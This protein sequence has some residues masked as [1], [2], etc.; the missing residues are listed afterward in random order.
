M[1]IEIT[2]AGEHLSLLALFAGLGV[3]SILGYRK[4]SSAEGVATTGYE[5]LPF[6]LAGMALKRLVYSEG[7]VRPGGF[8]FMA[9]LFFGGFIL[10]ASQYIKIEAAETKMTFHRIV[11]LLG[12]TVE[13]GEI[14]RVNVL[15]EES[16][17][18]GQKVLRARLQVRT[19]DDSWVEAPAMPRARLDRLLQFIKPKVKAARFVECKA[20]RLCG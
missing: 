12:T 19:K 9:V 15:E 14:D 8:V 6:G 3:F 2:P 13:Y 11:P 20:G 17:D 18:R 5:S 1:V 7:R 16:V 4:A 10:F